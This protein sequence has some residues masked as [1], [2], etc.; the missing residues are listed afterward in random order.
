MNEEM[1]YRKL[2]SN[3]RT[4]ELENSGKYLYKTKFKWEH[5]IEKLV[6]NGE[7]EIL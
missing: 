5:K 1:A 7:K 6:Q 3:T 2:T 4:L